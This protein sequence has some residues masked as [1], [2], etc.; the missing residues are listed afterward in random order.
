MSSIGFFCIFDFVRTINEYTLC[1][2]AL[3]PSGELE[4]AK[5]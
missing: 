3:P 1:L 5:I 4:G 2:L